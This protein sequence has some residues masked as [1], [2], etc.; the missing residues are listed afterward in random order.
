MTTKSR[1]VPVAGVR[2]H[3]AKHSWSLSPCGHS[4][5]PPSTERAAE[6]EPDRR[7]SDDSSRAPTAGRAE[8]A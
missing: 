5:Y 6:P 8:R 3:T 1:R 4:T 7:A 2:E